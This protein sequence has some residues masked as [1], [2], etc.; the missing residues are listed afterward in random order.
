MQ[1]Y[2]TISMAFKEIQMQ[3]IT[4]LCNIQYELCHV[5]MHSP[6]GSYLII[7]LHYSDHLISGTAQAQHGSSPMLKHRVPYAESHPPGSNLRHG[8]SPALKVLSPIRRVPY[9][10]IYLITYLIMYI[11]ISYIIYHINII[12]FLTLTYV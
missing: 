7:S 6:Y 12:S 10:G 1:V 4:I 2:I 11:Q 5:C 9:T 3:Y 8:S